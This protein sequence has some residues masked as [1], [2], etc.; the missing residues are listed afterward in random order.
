MTARAVCDD[1]Q[2]KRTELVRVTSCTPAAD[3]AT[4]PRDGGGSGLLGAAGRSEVFAR[5]TDP[6]TVQ[7]EW[8][9]GG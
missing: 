6:L 2:G 3:R 4:P 8:A 9:D 5:C 1:L 7:Q